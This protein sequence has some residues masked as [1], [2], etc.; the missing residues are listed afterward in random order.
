M[1]HPSRAK[2]SAFERRLVAWLRDHGF[3]E[4]DRAYGEGR[5]DDCGDVDGI[6]G[7]C[8]QARNTKRVE[9][10]AGLDAA[11]RQARGR[12]P[13]LVLHRRGRAD[14]G[15]AFAV[16][17]LADLAELLARDRLRE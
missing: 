2:G 9:L 8:V 10:G 15:E 5:A 16:L 14:P 11:R 6:D 12:L 17:A 3:P 13:V 7:V 1:T 4:A